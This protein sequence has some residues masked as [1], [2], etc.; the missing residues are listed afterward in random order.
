MVNPELATA[1]N[2]QEP[3]TVTFVMVI[4][5]QKFYDSHMYYIVII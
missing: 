4:A 5:L 3:I 1:T 2:E